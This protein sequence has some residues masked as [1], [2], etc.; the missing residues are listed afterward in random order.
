MLLALLKWP[1]K[2]TTHGIMRTVLRIFFPIL[3]LFL[4]IILL[5]M[6][7]TWMAI[8]YSINMESIIGIWKINC[9]IPPMDTIMMGRH[10][11]TREGN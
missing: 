1:L 10:R 3:K 2:N 8:Q 11:R 9:L 6:V 4:H 7:L 5:I